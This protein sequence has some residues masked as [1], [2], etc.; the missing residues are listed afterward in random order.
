MFLP[1]SAQRTTVETPVVW[2]DA[3]ASQPAGTPFSSS[4]FAPAGQA[5]GSLP[6][7]TTT[8]LGVMPGTQAPTFGGAPVG[9]GMTMGGAPGTSASGPAAAQR[10][11][12]GRKMLKARRPGR[13]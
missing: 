5:S 4:A 8:Q 11:P 13:K 6:A 1:R 12:A 7:F 10:A 2:A 3:G 9:G